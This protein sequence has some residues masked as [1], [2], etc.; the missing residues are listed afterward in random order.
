MIESSRRPRQPNLMGSVYRKVV[1]SLTP[2]YVRV[3]CPPAYGMAVKEPNPMIE[4]GFI[5]GE[6]LKM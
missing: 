6:L 2:P 4:E 1:Q 3:L 5:Q